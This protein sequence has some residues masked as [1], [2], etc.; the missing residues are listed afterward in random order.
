MIA[1]DTNVL[2]R[3]AVRDDPEQTALADELIDAFTTEEPGL[4]TLIVL[5]ECWWVLGSSYSHPSDRRR[6]FVEALLAT[7]EIRVERNDTVRAALRRTSDG[8]DLADALIAQ[9]AAEAGCTTVMTFDKGAARSAGMQLL[10]HEAV[11][12]L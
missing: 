7:Q 11:A 9:T 4:V 10:T 12:G 1:I 5:V 2:V 6:E 8:G 3:Y